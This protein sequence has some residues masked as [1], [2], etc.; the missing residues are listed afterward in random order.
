MVVFVLVWP[1]VVQ[2][3]LADKRMHVTFRMTFRHRGR[4][5]HGPTVTLMGFGVP[6]ALAFDLGDGPVV[7]DLVPV[8]GETARGI[9]TAKPER[10]RGQPVDDREDKRQRGRTVA[11]TGFDDPA[12]EVSDL[13]QITFGRFRGGQR[14]LRTDGSE[15][16]HHDRRVGIP[17]RRRVVS[18]LHAGA[19]PA[20]GELSRRERGVIVFQCII[21]RHFVQIFGHFVLASIA[22]STL[23][24]QGR[25]FGK[26]GG[27]RLVFNVF[28]GRHFGFRFFRLPL[29]RKAR[30]FVLASVVFPAL[31]FRGRHFDFR[32]VRAL[33]RGTDLGRVP[34]LERFGRQV[35]FLADHVP[36]DG[37]IVPSDRLARFRIDGAEGLLS[38]FKQAKIEKL[39]DATLHGLLTQ[40]ACSRDGSYRG[41]CGR[42]VIVVSFESEIR[43]HGFGRVAYLVH[44]F[45][46]PYHGHHSH[47][48]TL[49][50]VYAV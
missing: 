30:H 11:V 23:P 24:L 44:V 38:G 29:V 16:V 6:F 39:V 41:P 25:H 4:L 13:G 27:K 49:L 5:G 8:V 9:D 31:R 36:H 45:L 17:S 12:D 37:L 21:G 2:D 15:M 19:L 14:Q 28:Q 32:L 40:S 18:V 42:P 7:G 35:R 3:M 33:H 10:V 46:D 47:D 34:V 43:E 26:I 22:F 1:H 50:P 48:R 20:C